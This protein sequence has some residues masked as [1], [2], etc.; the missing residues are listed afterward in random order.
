[1][2]EIERVQ[3]QEKVDITQIALYTPADKMAQLTV[4][5]TGAMLAF[6]GSKTVQQFGKRGFRHNGNTKMEYLMDRIFEYSRSKDGM[7]LSA[8]LK[9]AQ[10][11]IEV[12]P[13]ESDGIGKSKLFNMG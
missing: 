11:Q 7:M 3:E 10:T 4:I 8:M 6:A 5:P 2:E 1:M 9:L 13:V 12:T